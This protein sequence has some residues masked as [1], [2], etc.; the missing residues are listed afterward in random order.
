MGAA[1]PIEMRRKALAA[2][3][4]GEKKLHVSRMF[5]I[6]RNTLDEWLKRRAATREVAPKTY[7]RRGPA[8]KI[9]DLAEFRQ[10]AE[11]RGHLTQQQMADEWPKP[12]SNRTMGKALK[13]MLKRYG[14]K[15]QESNDA[16]KVSGKVFGKC[17]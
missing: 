10:F 11:R 15:R 8:P 1:Y 14:S 5:G 16:H 4:R 12:V 2:V 7:Q 13:A 6:S 3:E 9:A 17:R